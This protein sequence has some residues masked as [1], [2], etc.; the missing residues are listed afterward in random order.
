MTRT[1]SPSRSGSPSRSEELSSLYD[2]SDALAQQRLRNLSVTVNVQYDNRKL[3][4]LAECNGS[5]IHHAQLVDHDVAVADRLVALRF[6]ITLG[7]GGIDA[8]DAGGLDD[9]VGV[10]LDRAQGSRRVGRE[11]GIARARREDH[12]APL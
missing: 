4:F 10:D 11:V 8:V 2:R 7:I 9:D 1:I 12:H 5:L 6:R 3:V